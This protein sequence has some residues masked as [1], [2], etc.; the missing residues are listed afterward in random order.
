MTDIPTT[1]SIYHHHDIHLKSTLHFLLEEG[2]VTKVRLGR[3]KC[4]TLCENIH[5]EN[6]VER[7]TRAS[8]AAARASVTTDEGGEYKTTHLRPV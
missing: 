1:D 4:C 7:C 5:R 3:G 2:G 8:V 6:C